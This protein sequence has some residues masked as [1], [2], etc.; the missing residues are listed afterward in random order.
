[1]KSCVSRRAFLRGGGSLIAL[2]FLEAAGFR[3]FAA[4][5]R[6]VV[7]PPKRMVFLGIG[8][9]VTQETW[10]PDLK[11]RGTNYTM[12]AGLA[13]LLRH[14]AD[15]TI[16][17]GLTNKYTEEAHWGSTFWLTGANRFEGGA[18]FHNSVS[19]DQV[20]AG[21]LGKT[22][23]FASLQ[24]NGTDPDI[25]GNGHGPGLSLAWD[26]RGKPVAGLNKPIA[27]FHR[28][29]SS[30]TTPIEARRAML[31]Q[32]RSVLDAVLEDARDLQRTLGKND[33]AKLDEYFQGIRDIEAVLSKEEQWQ[34]LPKPTAPFEAPS[35][36]LSGVEEVKLM[37][38]LIVAAFQ[39]DCT[40]VMTYRQPISSLLLS[41]G[42]KV[43]AHDMSHYSAGERLEASQRRDL[44][45]SELLAGLIDKLKATPE[46]D[47][48][49]L[50][51]HTCLVFGSNIR[52]VHHLDN[53]PT[54][55]AGGG[56]GI[57]LGRHVVVSKD[58]PLCNAW[59]TLLRGVGIDVPRHGDSTGVIGELMA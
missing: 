50:F 3:R 39:T 28:L 33:N 14:K 25:T 27:A 47:G 45:Q 8:Y 37:Y 32:K 13:P 55:L 43:A 17:Q 18:G 31:V 40:R 54:I 16:V 24:L 49:R 5:S 52:N 19:V 44:V 41:L 6:A 34:S 2:P 29:F 58:T 26:I 22:T 20:A 35:S 46:V 38:N 56:A 12:P 51:D 59:L 30:D 7:A 53:C 1:M 42:I 15:F 11:Q 4:A 23:R 9:G 48:S 36:G 10:Y 57:K 21:V